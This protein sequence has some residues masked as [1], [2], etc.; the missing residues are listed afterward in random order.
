MYNT[1]ILPEQCRRDASLVGSDGL[2]NLDQ[3]RHIQSDN[4]VW[5]YNRAGDIVHRRMSLAFQ[6][7][8]PDP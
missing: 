4:R 2:S 3:Q 7:P 5:P 6:R 1:C 8:T